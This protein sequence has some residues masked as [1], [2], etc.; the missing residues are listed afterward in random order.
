MNDNAYFEQ[1]LEL[2]NR[3]RRTGL[4]QSIELVFVHRAQKPA[5]R[6]VVDDDE[7]DDLEG[8]ARQTTMPLSLVQRRQMERR[9][10]LGEVFTSPLPAGAPFG[11][12]PAYLGPAAATLAEAESAQA[13]SVT[14]GQLLGLPICCAAA[15]RRIQDG[16]PWLSCW[17]EQIIGP[18]DAW[19][20]ILAGHALGWTPAG[21]YFPC[22]HDCAETS[23]RMRQGDAV[24][25]EFELDALAD[26]ARSFRLRPILIQNEDLLFLADSQSMMLDAHTIAIG[27]N[28]ERWRCELAAG[29]PMS[30]LDLLSTGRIQGR[31]L[32]FVEEP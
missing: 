2:C 18:L 4:T 6:L 32:T 24:L 27:P 7:L 28:A 3:L 19:G 17:L 20:N 12:I 11:A 22:R 1:A 26:D 5:V 31:L 10:S 13:P 21:E 16:Q 14:L 15:Y 23:M 25:R 8:F 29:P 30:V 9:T